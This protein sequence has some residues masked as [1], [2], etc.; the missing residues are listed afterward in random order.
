MF[1]SPLVSLSLEEM[2]GNW[3]KGAVLESFDAHSAASMPHLVRRI[4]RSQRITCCQVVAP[5]FTVPRIPTPNSKGQKRVELYMYFQ[6]DRSVRSQLSWFASLNTD[7]VGRCWPSV[8]ILSISWLC[9]PRQVS[10]CCSHPLCEKDADSGTAGFLQV[11][12]WLGY[13]NPENKC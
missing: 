1:I 3:G 10:G 11:C 8:G 7:L 2:F 6:W 4:T 9:K 12:F 13:K 5:R